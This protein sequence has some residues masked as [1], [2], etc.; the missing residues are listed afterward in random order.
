MKN[1]YARV[2]D[3]VAAMK[4]LAL[5]TIVE[6][7]G[8]APQK[9]G[10]SALFSEEGLLCGTLGGGS[11]EAQAQSA[12]LQSLNRGS[13]SVLGLALDDEVVEPEGALCGGRVK[14][15]VDVSIAQATRTLREFHQS[16]SLRHS[17]L[18]VTLI[19][20][21]H[22]E[23]PDVARHWIVHDSGLEKIGKSRAFLFEVEIGA[24]LAEGQVA[25]PKLVKKVLPEDGQEI[26]AFLE[27]QAPLPRLVIAGAG[28]I[29]QALSGLGSLLDFEVTV[30]DDRF[31]YASRDRFPEADA[32]IIEDIGRAI[33]E[34]PLGPDT[35]VV[36]VTRG[37]ARDA[38]A[39]RASI[40]RGAAYI[41][42]IGS[43]RKVALMRENFVR[44]GWAKESDLDLVHSPVGLQIGSKT[45]GE[46][47]VSI[48]AELV[49]VRSRARL[50]VGGAG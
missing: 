40:G 45:V 2:L 16:L 27:P 12:A 19:T 39:L 46:I 28:H 37:H 1:F 22:G 4:P 29:G 17:G 20:N 7:E 23:T 48:A 38:D 15:L 18:L 13:S 43:K 36:I 10:A 6:A 35:Y 9:A 11:V 26:W 31:D 33:Q 42:M 44:N 50:K 47:A 32:V 8:S 30:I 49:L 14:I 41:G 34:L 21:P 24:A 3:R 5:C 25:Q